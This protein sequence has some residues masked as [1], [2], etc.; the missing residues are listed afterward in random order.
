MGWSRFFRRA[1]WDQ[2]RADELEAHLAHERDHHQARG[3]S[4]AE[5]DRA[6]RRKL[7][8][9]VRIREDIYEMNTLPLVDTLWQDLRYGA[10]MLRKRP[11][12]TLVAILSL[13]IGIGANSAVFS[14]V[15]AFILQPAP[16]DRPEELVHIYAQSGGTDYSM[17]SYPDVEELVEGTGDVFTDVGASVFTL[18]RVDGTDGVSALMG[19]AVTGNLLPLLGI[20]AEV[21]RTFGPADDLAAGAHPV[22]ML[23]YGYWQ[24]V[25]GGDDSV[26]GTEL[27]LGGRAY[28]VI[29]V[30]PDSYTGYMRGIQADL[31]VPMAMYDDL[32]GVPMLDERDSHSLIGVARM[33]PGVSLPQAEA[34]LGA[35]AT[36]LDDALL[37]GWNLGDGF[38]AVPTLEVLLYPALDPYL[39]AVAW[40]LMVVVGLVLLLACTNLASFLLARAHDRRREV[41]VRL[42]LGASRGALIRQLLTETTLL[43]ALGGLGGLGLAVGLLAWLEGADFPLPFGLNLTLDLSPDARV[44]AFTAAVSAVAGTMLGL[45]P[46]MQSTRPDVVPTLKLESVGGGR[47]GQIRWRNGLIVA[48]LTV[49]LT[50]LIG[51]GLF[52]RSF[53][54]VNAIDPGFGGQPTAML[55]VMVPNTRFSAEESKRYIQRLV[56][57]FES[58]P[59]IEQ[60]GLIDNMPLDLMSNGIYFLV[61]GH[62]APSNRPG[63]R[64]ERAAV[65]PS[66][67]GAAG[68]PLVAGRPFR[69][70]DGPDGQPVAIVSEAMARQFWPD[71]DAVGRT[72]ERPGDDNVD[73]L[74]VGIAAD[75][76]IQSLGEAPGWHV[77]LPY[78]QQPSFLV[79][80]LGRTTG[81]DAQAARTMA[82]AARELDPQVTIWTTSTLGRHLAVPRLPSQLGA[83]VISLFAVLALAL[84]VIGLYGVVSYSVA[85][86][87]R[88]VGI[89]M[90]LGASATAITR[91]LLAGGLRLVL[92][93]SV[94]GLAL[95]FV[96]SRLVGGLLVDTGPTDLVAFLG[97]PL[98]LGVT[99]ALASYLPARRA[100]RANP[101]AALRAD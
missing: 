80:F 34:A 64:A 58:L 97:A 2:E 3:L 7:G 55:S 94:L 57:R 24:R 98:V 54:Q 101:V 50:L 42:A 4:A 46:A 85:A 89:R 19:E 10:R 61:D 23:G 27:R 36:A 62:T 82:G 33:A 60:V 63:F 96:A 72:F 71:G 75:I 74:V 35:V 100:S 40:L 83:L 86:R 28:T 5:A 95:S 65:D 37:P 25:F 1:R 13:A 31:F 12:F 53:Q 45:L 18:A 17:L 21:G 44:L 8:N 68:I 93:G 30:V 87:G 56:E 16:Y 91:Q 84:A 41:A 70:T 39:K 49:S 38:T 51:A 29:G 78:T 6:A 92:V 67:F 90:A 52:L 88:E 47:P 81:D 77:Y 69:E 66:F 22:V 15:N 76:P 20:E 99:A 73:V 14:L 32:M 11:G 43:G 79:H 9:T 48:Q 26:V 59:G